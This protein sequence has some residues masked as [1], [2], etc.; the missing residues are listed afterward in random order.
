VGHFGT[1]Q[2]GQPGVE[3][4]DARVD[5][6]AQ[7]SHVIQLGASAAWGQARSAPTS[8]FEQ[9]ALREMHSCANI[10]LRSA[11]ILAGVSGWFVP[12]A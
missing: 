12:C 2:L 6:R 1:L 7:I 11:S 9:L 4:C 8:E 10:I 3:S 5:L